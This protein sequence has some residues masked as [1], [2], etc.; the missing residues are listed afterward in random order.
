MI[1]RAYRT[2]ERL[3]LQ[4][5]AEDEGGPYQAIPQPGASWQ[6]E[7]RPA[8][9]PHEY[10]RG[11]VAKLLTLFRPATGEARAEAVEQATNA[12]L[13]PWLRRELAAILAACP[14]PPAGARPVVQGGHTQPIETADE[15]G[16]RVAD[17]PADPAGRGGQGGPIRDRQQRRRPLMSLQRLARATRHRLQLLPLFRRQRPKRL[18]NRSRH[19]PTPGHNRPAEDYTHCQS[20]WQVTH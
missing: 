1:E 3:G 19:R 17:P 7:G 15:G 8:R 5:W 20:N 18:G 2:G 6:P 10:I 14:P 16:D 9:Y 12:V 11:G 4:V 13:H